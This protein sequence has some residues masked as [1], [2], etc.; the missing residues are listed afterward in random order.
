MRVS[1]LLLVVLCWSYAEEAALPPSIQNVITRAEAA[2]IK[3]RSAYDSANEKAFGAAEKSLKAELEKLTKAGKL[4]EAVQVKKLME[5]FR[6]D[7]V[8]K[9]DAAAMDDK[10]L[11]GAES[12]DSIMGKL[13]E[14]SGDWELF[15]NGASKGFVTF[16]DDGKVINPWNENW[17]I[18][19]KSNKATINTDTSGMHHITISEIGEDRMKGTSGINQ[20]IEFRKK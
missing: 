1:A 18:D 9:V 10:P 15:I 6:R 11:L 2:V 17:N 5:T 16:K 3:N 20:A 12:G 14:I 4:E 8:T 7:V 19:A 13:S